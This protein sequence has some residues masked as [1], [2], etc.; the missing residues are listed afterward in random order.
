MEPQKKQKQIEDLLNKLSNA[1]S[2]TADSVIICDRAGKI[3]YANP[4]FEKLTGYTADEVIGKTP[5]ILKSGKHDHSF[6]D[7]LWSAILSGKVF[8]GE[9][10]NKTKLG[11]LYC[12]A[13]T[14]TPI[15]DESGNVTSFVSTGRDISEHKK[16]E[17]TMMERES[18]RRFRIMADTAPVMIWMTDTELSFNYFNKGWLD[19]S[20]NKLEHEIGDGWVKG[21]HDEDIDLVLNDFVSKLKSR[22][23]FSMEFRLKRYDGEFRWFLNTGAPRFVNDDDFLGY[24][25]SCVDITERRM[26]EEAIRS[27]IEKHADGIL[28]VDMEGIVRFTNP[29]AEAIFRRKKE[30]LIGENFGM[31]AVTGKR[32]ELDIVRA[33]GEAGIAEMRVDKTEWDGKTAHLVSLR[34]ITKR[35]MAEESLRLSEASLAEAQRIAHMGD[36]D[37]DVPNNKLRWS[38]EIYS[39]FRLEDHGLLDSYED[40]LSFVHPDDKEFVTKSVDDALRG[41]KNYSIDHRIVLPNGAERVVHEK[42]EVTFN[43]EGKPLRM[44]GTLQDITESRMIEI[45]LFKAQKLESVGILAGGIAHDFNNI[46]AGI[47]GNTNLAMINSKGAPEL[48]ETLSKIETATMRAKDLTQQL[49][50][51]SKGGAPVKKTINVIEFIK[52]SA[53]FAVRGANVRCDYQIPDD[54][55]SVEAD[56]GQLNQVINN[57][58]INASQAMPKG[59]IINLAAENIDEQSS[60]T[61]SSLKKGI[62]VKISIIDHG[63]G[64]QKEHL[65]NI[66]DPYFTT[67]QKGSGLGLATSYSIVKNHGGIIIPESLPGK[68]ATFNIFL[69]ASSKLVEEKSAGKKDMLAG[70]GKILVMDDEEI[71]RD[72]TKQLLGFIGYDVECAKDGVEAIEL[73]K[74]AKANCKPFDIVIMDLTVPGGMGGEEA[75]TKL[76]EFDNNVK[77]IVFSGYS[78]NPILSDYKKYGFDGVITKPFK[79]E[80]FNKVIHE[81]MAAG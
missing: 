62:Y 79:I 15:I 11:I 69:P 67:K 6:Y 80:E 33:T 39:I 3:E 61:I 45:E 53:G 60:P 30:K 1:V 7:N 10:I 37:W 28:I 43:V 52:E 27:I 2:C 51:F 26:A 12:Q 25:G 41:K 16:L 38:D 66:F 68:G 22:E 64:I 5:Q 54:L 23:K 63:I 50:T 17:Q 20:G 40:F 19:Y 47:L 21:V 4:A 76:R 70:S 36:W 77:T 48:D 74:S 35:K 31:P 78:N 72:M 71:I 44:K 75:V 55:W 18:E 73:Y 8:R 56:E 9:F 14:I 58:V 81:T 42:A 57:L 46:L 13:E 24:I 59:G 32:T 34:D 29:S 65:A 49:L